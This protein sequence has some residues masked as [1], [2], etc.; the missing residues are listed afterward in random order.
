MEG[1]RE[2]GRFLQTRQEPH[3][4]RAVAEAALEGTGERAGRLHLA[5]HRRHLGPWDVVMEQQLGRWGLE[6]NR[7][8]KSHRAT[9][10][11]EMP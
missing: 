11:R 9:I 2:A 6:S 3:G 7:V 5:E 10:Q 4:W 8:R 1:W